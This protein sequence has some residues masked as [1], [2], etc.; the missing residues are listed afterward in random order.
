MPT[1]YNLI[2]APNTHVSLGTEKPDRVLLWEIKLKIAIEIV[3]G[4][5]YLHSL[6]HLVILK[7]IKSPSHK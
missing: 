7:N 2:F 3:E 5:S 1:L 6:E 4:L